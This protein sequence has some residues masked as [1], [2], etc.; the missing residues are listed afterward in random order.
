[1]A[2][3]SD[4]KERELFE[5]ALQRDGEDR[6]QVLEQACAGN[7]ELERRLRRLLAAHE[8]AQDTPTEALQPELAP[9][10][11]ERIGSYRLLE[12]IGE[13]G[14]GVVYVAAQ[15]QPVRRKVA[16]KLIK[17]GMDT[18]EVIARFH[19]ER[20][21]LALMNHPNIARILDA[22][23]TAEGRPYFVMEYVPGMPLLAYCDQRR[24]GIAERLDLFVDVCMAVQHAHQKGVVHRDIKPSNILVME[25]GGH[26]T[27]K[28]IDFGVAKAVSSRLSDLTLHTRL[29]GFVG[30][31]AY[32]SPEQ[33]KGTGLDVDT[34]SDVYSL[35]AVLYELLTGARPFDFSAPGLGLTE[36]QKA[37]LERDPVLPSVRVGRGGEPPQLPPGHPRP[38]RQA[39]A[40]ALR[41]DL[42]WLIMKALD[43][44]RSRRY[45]SASELAADIRRYL[46][47]Q[48][49]MAGPPSATYRLS[50]F[51]RRHAAA[52][53]VG[54]SIAALVV[55]LIGFYT[56]QLAQER[57]RANREARR[58]SQ[59]AAAAER[60]SEFLVNLFQVSDPSQAKGESITAREL[61]DQGAGSIA[62]ELADQPQ[63]QARLLAT[64][65]QVYQNLGLYESAEQ[66]LERA[67]GL[68]TELL[69]KE[70][71]DVAESLDHLAWLFQASGSYEASE[72]FFRRSLAMQRKLLGEEHP[73]VADSLSSLGGLLDRKGEGE[74]AE[75]LLRQALATWRKLPGEEQGVATSLNNLALFLKRKGNYEAAEALY[76]EALAI[77]RRVLGDEHPHTAISLNN[78][79]ALL[80]RQG[81]GDLAEPLFR[82]ALALRRKLFGD[83]HPDVA[84]SLN[85]LATLLREKGELEASEQL[86]RQAIEMDR[87]LLGPRHPD[88]AIHLANLARVLHARGQPAAAEPLFVEA[89]GIFEEAF[90]PDHW[91]L[92]Q[93]RVYYGACLLELGRHR[94]AEA[95]MLAGHAALEKTLGARHERTRG[96]AAGLAELYEAWGRPTDCAG[97]AC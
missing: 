48:P 61:L 78:L 97:T 77:R 38:D 56:I 75:L 5:A 74:E 6:D 94:E 57:D 76:R 12:R 95:Q 59:E 87:K 19:S 16:L 45:S 34:R 40:R 93:V 24:L 3:T 26:P 81:D 73:A 85:N 91:Q 50:K 32:V 79:G 1:M 96:A 83:E 36:I 30:T 92:A 72:A 80:V 29:G 90:R 4:R 2:Q 54:A 52:V 37:I 8:L 31:P 53:S 55:G 44:D 47:Q 18:R 25:E 86:F 89:L 23:A 70:H 60:V 15:E 58:A 42:D 9:E 7:P 17:A 68:R 28:V 33:A 10:D 62:Q 35:G 39:V 14:M 27:P 63:I 46:A 82:E 69:G 65:G 11:P 64:M 88:L 21:A 71:P 66:L 67:L 41:H 20:Q 13:G 22:S 49:V 51:L 43:K 84:T